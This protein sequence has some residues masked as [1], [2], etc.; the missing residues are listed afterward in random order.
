V[1]DRAEPL[2]PLL[3]QPAPTQ[4]LLGLCSNWL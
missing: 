4:R 1:L 3:G 2:D